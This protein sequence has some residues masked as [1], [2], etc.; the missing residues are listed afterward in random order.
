MMMLCYGKFHFLL[1][2]AP[3]TQVEYADE[4]ATKQLLETLLQI[5]PK[6]QHNSMHNGLILFKIK[7]YLGPQCNLKQKVLSLIHDSPLRGH[8]GYLKTL[9]RAKRD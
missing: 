9:Q 1:N 6:D 8:S 5:Q 3:W 7:I 4:E 2:L